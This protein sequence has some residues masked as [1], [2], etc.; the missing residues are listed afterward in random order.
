MRLLRPTRYVVNTLLL[1]CLILVA[2]TA[3]PGSAQPSAHPDA[4]RTGAPPALPGGPSHPPADVNVTSSEGGDPLTTP[5]PGALQTGTATW[6]CGAG[7]RCPRGHAPGELIAAIDRKDTPWDKGDVVTVEY[8]CGDGCLRAVRV[9]VVDV[10][11]CKGR[12]IID[13]SAAAFSR[14]APLSRGVIPVT[15]SG[16]GSIPTLPPTDVER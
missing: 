6:Y 3:T 4:A 1:S 2:C 12:R 15:V 11:A 16:A 5:M 8:R 7:S 10:C 9:R 14:L 13:L